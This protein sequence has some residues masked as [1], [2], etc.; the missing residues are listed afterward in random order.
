M[1]IAEAIKRIYDFFA[2]GWLRDLVK[3]ITT[4]RAHFDVAKESVERIVVRQSTSS[5]DSSR[6]LLALPDP[7][8]LK[9]E[10]QDRTALVR[11]EVEEMRERVRTTKLRGNAGVRV[12]TEDSS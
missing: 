3:C 10:L 8:S 9:E 5:S 2:Q 1:T 7:S 11:D 4:T 12:C 6:D